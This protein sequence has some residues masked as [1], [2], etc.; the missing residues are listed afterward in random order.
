MPPWTCQKL[1]RAFKQGP[2]RFSL[3]YIDFLHEEFFDMINKGQ[4]MVPYQQKMYYTYQASNC[5]PQV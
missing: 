4:W 2:H 1:Q 3:Q 5:P